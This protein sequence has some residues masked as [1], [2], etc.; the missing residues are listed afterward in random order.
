MPSEEEREAMEYVIDTIDSEQV[1]SVKNQQDDNPDDVGD[2]AELGIETENQAKDI[3]GK[4]LDILEQRLNIRL[5]HE[6]MV[7]QLIGLQNTRIERN[8]NVL[9]ARLAD[10]EG[11]RDGNILE[12]TGDDEPEKKEE[13]PDKKEEAESD[14]NDRGG[15]KQK[16]GIKEKFRKIF[17]A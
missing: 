13:A 3:V 14:P 10:L 6:R 5:E 9:L 7:N 17:K 11:R 2:R 4:R 16:G 12:E 1:E 15:G 8:Q